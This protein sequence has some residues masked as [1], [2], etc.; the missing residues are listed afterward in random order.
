MLL[1]LFPDRI[2]PSSLF[3]Y[4]SDSDFEEEE[5][6]ADQDSNGQTAAHAFICSHIP[7]MIL[8]VAEDDYRNDYPDSDPD[9]SSGERNNVSALLMLI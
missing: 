8:A 9:A 6:E 5:D 7:N 4:D 3:M 1:T 2:A